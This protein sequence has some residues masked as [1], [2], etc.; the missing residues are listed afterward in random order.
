MWT[1]QS[2]Q[3]SYSEVI[4]KSP[5]ETSILNP[6]RS[7]VVF[8]GSV[9]VP[10]ESCIVFVP[11][12]GAG[13]AKHL[14]VSLGCSQRYLAMFNNSSVVWPLFWK[15]E[16]TAC[17]TCTGLESTDLSSLGFEKLDLQASTPGVS[18][19]SGEYYGLHQTSAMR[20]TKHLSHTYLKFPK[21]VSGFIL[22]VWT[23]RNINFCTI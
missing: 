17:N 22:C 13:F 15:V 2:V 21:L 16:V 5:W 7:K 18:C 10:T 11:Y 23:Q 14:P 1:S 4:P 12:S 9:R 3:L 19:C 6:H 8:L 20:A